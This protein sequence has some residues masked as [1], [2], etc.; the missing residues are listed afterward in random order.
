MNSKYALRYLC[1]VLSNDALYLQLHL[2]LLSSWRIEIEIE[3]VYNN[4]GGN[5]LLSPCFAML[6]LSFLGYTVNF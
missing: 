4:I 1:T 3:I 6:G 5:Q 2:P